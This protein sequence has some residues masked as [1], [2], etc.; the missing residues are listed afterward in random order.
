ME[1]KTSVPFIAETTWRASMK[2]TTTYG[3]EHRRKD[4]IQDQISV[5][6]VVPAGSKKSFYIGG[7]KYVA[8]IPW[9]SDLL[10]TF[11]DGSEVLGKTGGIYTG[12]QVVILL[13]FVLRTIKE[14]SF[15]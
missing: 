6:D 11:A 3:Q 13:I 10:T 2:I 5:E 1:F 8:D 4:S 15:E 9:E 7:T 12:I 14:L